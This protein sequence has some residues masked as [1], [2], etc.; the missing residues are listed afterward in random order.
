MREITDP[1]VIASIER[2]YVEHPMAAYGSA[3]RHV[4]SRGNPNAVS[5]AGAI[6]AD[7]FMPETA[8]AMGLADPRDPVMSGVARDLLLAENY[9]RFNDP[10]KALQAYNAG[11][12]AVASGRPLPKE[13][14]DYVPKVLAAMGGQSG[15]KEI[16]DPEII[17]RLEGRAP[18]PKEQP[19]QP[20]LQQAKAAATGKSAARQ[21]A[22]AELEA[23]R[24]KLPLLRVMDI[25]ADMINSKG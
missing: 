5:P 25:R 24:M 12:G 19:K 15:A 13:T 1:N 14:Q 16:T 2:G 20:S 4:E 9:A 23:M 6:G 7:Q 18:T 11:P 8:K 22:E 10:V 17:A 21:A 3:V